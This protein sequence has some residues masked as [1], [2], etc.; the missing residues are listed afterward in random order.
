MFFLYRR[1]SI[2][3]TFLTGLQ[4]FESG[5]EAWYNSSSSLHTNTSQCGS[6]LS[7]MGEIGSGMA[8]SSS[9]YLQHFIFGINWMLICWHHH[10]PNNVSIS[11]HWKCWYFLEPWSWK[12]FNL[13]CYF[14]VSYAFPPPVL[15]P[16]AP[17]TFLA[18]H[19]TG[20]YTLLVL[21][22]FCWME[23][24]WLPNVLGISEDILHL[25]A[26]VKILSGMFWSVRQ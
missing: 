8:F 5:Q 14:Q 1:Y 12:L 26:M 17:L 9:C 2:P 6:W 23:S 16:S 25:C 7:F 24:P 19:V 11:K 13:L 15:V 22:A 4:H 18:E 21:A 10:V 3:F 20:Q